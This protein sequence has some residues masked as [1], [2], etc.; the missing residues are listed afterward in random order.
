MVWAGIRLVFVM[1]ISI[2]ARFLGVTV[3]TLCIRARLK[4]CPDTKQNPQSEGASVAEIR[5]LPNQ[6]RKRRLQM[7]VKSRARPQSLL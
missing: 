4:S 6:G 2:K 1:P 7:A 5:Y 3:P